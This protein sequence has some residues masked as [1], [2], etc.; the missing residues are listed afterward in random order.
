MTPPAEHLPVFVY[1]TLRSGERNHAAYLRGRITSTT[2]ACLQHTLLYDG[3]GYPYAVETAEPALVH[4]DL[5]T[6]IPAE[7]ESLLA[8]LDHLEDY[9]PGDPRNLYERVAR[10]VTRVDGATTR[11]WVYVAAPRL[12][13]RLRAAGSPLPDGRWPI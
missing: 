9:S 8:A 4:G 11:A 5:I 1:G 10:E 3:P 7:Y 2:P 13:A 12:A 6:P